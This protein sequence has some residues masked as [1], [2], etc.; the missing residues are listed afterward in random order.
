METDGV[1]SGGMRHAV[2]AGGAQS[3]FSLPIAIPGKHDSKGDGYRRYGTGMTAQG[4]LTPVRE[5]DA[6]MCR[7]YLPDCCQY[8]GGLL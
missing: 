8:F 1:F 5:E 3:G 7:L 2:P 6:G 4:G